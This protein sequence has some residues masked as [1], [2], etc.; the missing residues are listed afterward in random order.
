MNPN[1]NDVDLS[2][3]GQ[4]GGYVRQGL[5]V[6][7][8]GGVGTMKTTW[9]GRAPKPLFLSVGAEG[10]DDALGM[11]PHLY[12]ETQPPAYHITNCKAMVEKVERI[13]RDYK[14]MDIN[15]VVIDSVTYYVDMWIAELN[16]LR[17]ND[18]KIKARMDKAGG[19]ATNMTM[20][21]WGILGMHMRD[22]AMKLHK[23]QLNVIWIALEK[24]NRVNDEQT[25]TSRVVSVDPYIRGETTIKL[26]GMCK[27]IIH[28]KKE[29]FPDPNVMG[30][31]IS[32]PKFYTSPNQLTQ[33]VRHKYGDLFP[34]GCLVDTK[35]GTFP[36]WEAIHTRIGNF[37]YRT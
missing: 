34:E 3:P 16:E 13:C 17:Y 2:Y 31:M 15:T 6:F 30:R 21:D 9:A 29:L 7:L 32:I 22:L 33:I 27:M 19:E 20:R 11:I 28:A 1:Y 25:G 12:G 5:T 36:T 4:A 14:S 37:V 10:G 24:E 18:P 8:F 35:F 23:T 26:P